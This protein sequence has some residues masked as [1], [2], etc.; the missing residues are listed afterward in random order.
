[1][2]FFPIEKMLCIWTMFSILY[3][4]QSQGIQA[5]RENRS[6]YF[7]VD[8]TDQIKYVDTGIMK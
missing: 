7:N 4:S 5:S 3:G 6:F 2:L 8:L 1:M